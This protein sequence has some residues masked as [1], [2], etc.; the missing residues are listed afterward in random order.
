MRAG[1]RGSRDYVV[2]D[3][4]PTSAVD[5]GDQAAKIFRQGA[6]ISCCRLLLEFELVD[7]ITL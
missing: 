1:H 4:S 3:G 7:Q 6:V 5:T 2:I